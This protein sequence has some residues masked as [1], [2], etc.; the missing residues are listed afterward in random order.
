MAAIPCDLAKGVRLSQVLLSVWFEESSEVLLSDGAAGGEEEAEEPEEGAAAPTGP[1]KN[2]LYKLIPERIAQS[3]GM[4]D[5]NNMKKTLMQAEA[6]YNEIPGGKEMAEAKEEKMKEIEGLKEQL[7]NFENKYTELKASW[8]PDPKAVAP[9]MNTLM[10]CATKGVYTFVAGGTF[11]PCTNMMNA[12]GTGKELY[13]E[14]E[15]VLSVYQKRHEIERNV[16]NT[17]IFKLV[18]N[19]F[20]EGDT[21]DYSAAIDKIFTNWGLPLELE[22]GVKPPKLDVLVL[23]WWDVKEGDPV[24]AAKA[25]LATNKVKALGLSN[26]PLEGLKMMVRAGVDVALVE[27]CVPLGGLEHEQ[28]KTIMAFCQLHGMKIV[29]SN[30]LLGGLLTSAHV[31]R[32]TC[33]GDPFGT[34]MDPIGPVAEG[35]LLVQNFGGWKAFQG[36][37]GTLSEVGKRHSVPLELVALR[38]YINRGCFPVI[39]VPWLG[40]D[41]MPDISKLETDFLEPSDMSQISKA[42]Y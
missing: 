36:L 38:Y 34:A 41:T 18:P 16:P 22:E 14:C 26:F 6:D 17:Y 27:L 11:W 32:V 3:D 12:F 13:A 23:Y 7:A 2:T 9:W 35:R 33:P 24:A 20:Q 31:G 8:D 29:L 39:G 28:T 10:D 5:F 1:S 25:I 40:V 37:L 21:F 15:K 19:V 30:A 42:F 4:N